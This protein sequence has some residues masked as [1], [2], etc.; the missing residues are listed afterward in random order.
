MRRKEMTT[1]TFEM[2]DIE[3]PDKIARDRVASYPDPI[4]CVSDL[5]WDEHWSSEQ[6]LMSRLSK[7]CRVLYV[8]RPVSPDLALVERWNK[9]GEFDAD[10]LSSATC[11]AFSIC[12]FCECNQ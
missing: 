5:F 12:S 3:A 11:P 7:R 10:N 8:E 9:S 4:V 2:S 6:Q 1:Q